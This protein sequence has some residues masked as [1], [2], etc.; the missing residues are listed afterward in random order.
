[1][2]CIQRR[3]IRRTPFDLR[4]AL[5]FVPD[6]IER[7]VEP[8]FKVR[9]LPVRRIDPREILEV[10]DDLLNSMN[11]FERFINQVLDVPLQKVEIRRR[12]RTADG[13]KKSECPTR[14]VSARS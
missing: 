2:Q 12:P 1:M 6:D 3:A 8:L 11:T 9:I 4:L 13:L 10:V 14:A 5:Y 7:A